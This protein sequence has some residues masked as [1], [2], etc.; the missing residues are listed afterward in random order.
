MVR[1]IDFCFIFF[2]WTN[3]LRIRN[4]G[5]AKSLFL[6]S[7]TAGLVPVYGTYLIMLPSPMAF[8]FSPR[9][10]L[11]V[12]GRWRPS[13]A[14]WDL[15]SH[16]RQGLNGHGSIQYQLKCFRRGGHPDKN[17]AHRITEVRHPSSVWL[18]M[19]DSSFVG[20]VKLQSK[21]F[22]SKAS[23][24]RMRSSLNLPPK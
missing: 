11:Q 12:R 15:V 5:R 9:H 22:C 20:V 3:V 18:S 4:S 21:K 16:H 23:P 24:P 6:S 19:A 1:P 17:L 14:N 10:S 8:D 2:L 13:L 7:T